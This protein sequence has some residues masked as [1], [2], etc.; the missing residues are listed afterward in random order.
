MLSI[1]PVLYWESY[2]DHFSCR[3]SYTFYNIH[4][5][6]GELSPGPLGLVVGPQS[7]GPVINSCSYTLQKKIA[8]LSKVLIIKVVL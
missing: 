5:V 1:P 3:L 4:M 8:G 6:D 7:V 2:S